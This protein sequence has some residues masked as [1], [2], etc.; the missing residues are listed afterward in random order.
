MAEVHLGHEHAR[1]AGEDL[2]EV[3]GEGVQVHEM[4]VSQA[5]APLPD[6][7]QCTVDGAPRGAPPQNE[8]LGV[9]DVAGDLDIGDVVGDASDLLGPE[10]DHLL[11]VL[12][13]VGDVAGDVLLLEPAD[14][15]LQARR[16]GDGP[17]AGQRLRVADVGPEAGV[18]FGIRA[19]GLGGER[20]ADVG[21][22]PDVRELPGLGPVGQV[23]VGEQDDG[24]PVLDGEAGCLDGGV[25]AVD[26]APG[27]DDRRGDS[28]WRPYMAMRRSA[29]SV[30][31][32]SRSRASRWMS[33]TMS[34]SSRLTAK[35]SV[36]PLSARPGP[37]VVV[38][39][40]WPP[41]LAPGA[42]PML[43]I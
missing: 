5:V 37:L 43:A 16:A 9:L 27:G 24:R 3:P 40:R 21:Q 38:T 11:V 12:G 15:V 32:G 34:G 26:R 42:A 19:V 14:A 7:S 23:A 4:C 25:E 35:P 36:S 33:M 2:P 6:S 8:R 31:V 17:L 20:G 10:A 13:V 1:V 29:A 22:R 41:K 28:A 30:L 18:A 39:P